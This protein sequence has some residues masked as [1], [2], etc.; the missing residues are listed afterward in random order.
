MYTVG[1]T[2]IKKIDLNLEFPVHKQPLT[3]ET[4]KKLGFFRAPLYVAITLPQT[5]LVSGQIILIKNST[6]S[7]LSKINFG[8]VKRV[9]FRSRKPMAKTKALISVV[10]SEDC[11]PSASSVARDERFEKSFEIPILSPSTLNSNR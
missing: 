9:L 7:N 2:V 8:L 4:S 10:Q 3:M 6:R 1:F 5:A 11:L